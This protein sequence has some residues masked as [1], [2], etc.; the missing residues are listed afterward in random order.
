MLHH[1]NHHFFSYLKPYLIKHNTS[2]GT[3][4]VFMPI[5]FNQIKKIIALCGPLDSYLHQ[6]IF[7][8]FVFFCFSHSSL[9]N[10]AILR[11]IP[12]RCSNVTTLHHVDMRRSEFSQL[13]TVSKYSH[14]VILSFTS[15]KCYC[16]VL[17]QSKFLHV[18]YRSALVARSLDICVKRIVLSILIG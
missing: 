8:K 2:S 6:F 4:Y 16:I 15:P 10:T 9:I 3:I 5:D 13:Y 12:F 14:W 1:S 18:Q 11:F 7:Q 17:K